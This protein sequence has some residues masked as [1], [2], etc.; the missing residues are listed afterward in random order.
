MSV[1]RLCAARACED[2]GDG[3]RG[4]QRIA[5]HGELDGLTAPQ[6][7]R[8]LDDLAPDTRELILDLS[9]LTF[10]DSIGVHAILI[11][12]DTPTATGRSLTLLEPRG[13][14]RDVLARLGLLDRL[15]V[16]EAGAR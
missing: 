13:Q 9:G 2:P 12:N 16:L 8:A 3:A 10:I 11:C 14:V 4:R 5:L 6:L 1:T 15:T 7:Q